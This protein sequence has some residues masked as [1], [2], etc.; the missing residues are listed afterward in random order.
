MNETKK[1]QTSERCPSCNQWVTTEVEHKDLPKSVDVFCTPNDNADKTWKVIIVNHM[2]KETIEFEASN[3]KDCRFFIENVA[4]RMHRPNHRIS[5]RFP[6]SRY[7]DS[8]SRLLG[9]DWNDYA[10][11]ICR[12]KKKGWYEDV[13]AKAGR[14]AVKGANKIHRLGYKKVDVK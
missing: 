10:D 7:D 3:M 8:S 1:H 14:S 13:V 2:K 11:D 4:F 5:V 6:S 12:S 9:V